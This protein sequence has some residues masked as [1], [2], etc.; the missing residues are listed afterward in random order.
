MYKR[1]IQLA[2]LKAMTNGK[3]KPDGVLVLTLETKAPAKDKSGFAGNSCLR[4]SS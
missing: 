3:R 4:S 1:N 2:M